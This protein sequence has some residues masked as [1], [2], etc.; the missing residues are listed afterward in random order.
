MKSLPLLLLSLCALLP[1]RLAAAAPAI[2]SLEKIWNQGEH[3]AFTDLIRF[4]DRWYC[5]FREGRGHASPD[6][7]VRVLESDDG[8]AWRSAARLAEEGIDLRDPKFS[9]T[10]DGRLM[11]VLGGSIMRDGSYVGRQTRVAFSRDGRIWTPLQKILAPGDWLW[12]V[13]WHGGKAYGVAYHGGGGLRGVKRAAFLHQS[14]DGVAWELITPL[15][16]P[17]A[18]ETTLRFL[19]SGEMIALSV[20]MRTSPR[21][22][23]IGSSR[24]PYR[25]WVW[26][27][28]PYALGGPNFIVLPD[29]RWLASTRN[30]LGEGKGSQTVLAWMTRDSIRPFLEFPSGGDNSYAG[31]VRQGD[32][33]WMSYYSSH[34]DK[35]SIYLARVRLNL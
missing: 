24:P 12:R 27:D 15:D 10:A 6:G 21:G 9:V 30:Y 4:D 20:D 28:V 19:E 18:S 22:T 17:G 32:E 2:V 3:N 23:R 29:G 7:V 16:L 8:R 31:L 26:R 35:T 34:E 5:T 25:D 11:V 13:T 1:L 14:S 33:L